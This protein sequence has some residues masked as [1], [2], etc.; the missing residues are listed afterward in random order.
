MRPAAGVLEDGQ[1]SSTGEH[2]LTLPRLATRWA[3]GGGGEAGGPW[4]RHLI[5]PGNGETQTH[6]TKSADRHTPLL[7]PTLPALSPVEIFIALEKKK[8][9]TS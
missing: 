6:P 1:V 3:G 5:S 2:A 7:S 9:K 4:G 8:I